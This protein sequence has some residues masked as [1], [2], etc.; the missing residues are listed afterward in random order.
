MT[1]CLSCDDLT[2]KCN[3]AAKYYVLLSDASLACADDARKGETA[4]TCVACPDNCAKCTDAGVCEKCKGDE[5]LLSSKICCGGGKYLK[6]NGS[7]V[8]ACSN[9]GTN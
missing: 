6:T 9:C 4:G 1:G 7:G 8:D 2:G 3:A 5:P